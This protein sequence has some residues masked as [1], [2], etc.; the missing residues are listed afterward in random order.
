MVQISLNQANNDLFKN[1][2]MPLLL[3]A[4]HIDNN[5][6]WSSP[7]HKHDELCEIIY[8][9]EGEGDFVIN[10]HTYRTKKDDIIV[11]NPGIVH[12]EKSNPQKPLKIFF[13]GIGNLSIEGI[14]GLTDGS[15]IPSLVAPIIHAD[16]YSYKVNNYISN[17]FDEYSSQGRGSKIICQYLLILLIIFILR[18]TTAPENLT[19]SDPNSLG[20]QIKEYIDENYTCDI[21]LNDIANHFYLSAYYISHIFK[22]EIGLSTINYLISRRINEAKKLLL[23]TNATIEEISS[24]VGYENCNYFS[25]LFKKITKTSPGRFRQENREVII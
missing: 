22:K 13:C 6:E 14:E 3:Y 20:Y 4:G 2:R 18:I 23:T 5:P 8:I 21:S 12:K 10:N 24:K 9:S 1:N 15:L 19:A 7:S 16:K 17:I 11:Y 25:M